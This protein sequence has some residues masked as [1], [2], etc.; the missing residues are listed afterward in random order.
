LR[1][2]EGRAVAVEMD[3]GIEHPFSAKFSCPVCSYSLP[4]LEPR[5][6]SF[7]NPMG[8]C[9]KCDGL[10]K[11]TFFDPRRIVAFP[12]LSLAS[13]AIKGWDK[14]NQFYYQMLASLANHY[15]FDLEAPFEQLSA[16]IQGVI[17]NGSGKEKSTFAYLNENGTR[18]YRKHS[19]EGI[20]PNMERR[21]KE[22]ESVA[23]RE[24]LGKTS[25]LKCVR[26][27]RG[28]ACAGRHATFGSPAW[29]FMR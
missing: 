7:N 2:A 21:Y 25:T 10:G 6:F 12:H 16:P 8:A 14:R 13:G 22:T 18:S 17:L 28:H 1:H 19:F 3:S 23:V 26:N 15:E 5:L 9:P 24:E 20:I 11:I 27:A 4:E 29:P